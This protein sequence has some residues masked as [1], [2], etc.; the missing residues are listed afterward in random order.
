MAAAVSPAQA[1]P[2]P[3]GGPAGQLVQFVNRAGGSEVGHTVLGAQRGGSSPSPRGALRT[4]DAERSCS[5]PA[6]AGD[7]AR[8]GSG[9]LWCHPL[10]WLK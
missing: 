3:Q 9:Y 4:E 5:Q 1:D 2:D 7:R 10:P 6:L 8:D